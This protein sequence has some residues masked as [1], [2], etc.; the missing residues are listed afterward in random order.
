MLN[1]AL[2][3]IAVYSIT[4]IIVGGKIF[5]PIRDYLYDNNTPVLNT[6]FHC[7]QCMGVWVSMLVCLWLGEL[8]PV[9]WFSVAGAA[10][11]IQGFQERYLEE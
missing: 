9:Y 6:A 8:D 10:L 4:G 7:Y 2:T 5:R 3:A 11:L 1:F